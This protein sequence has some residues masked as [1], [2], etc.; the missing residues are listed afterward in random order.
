MRASQVFDQSEP[1]TFL[2]DH[3]VDD[4]HERLAF[5]QHTP[6]RMLLDGFGSAGVADAPWGRDASFASLEA[7]DLDAPA[8]HQSASFDFIASINSLDTV[9]DL[10]GA[11]IQMRELLTPGGLAIASFIGGSSLLKLR[12]IMLMADGDRPAARMH[13]LIDPRSCPQLLG[14][15]GWRN[16]V[17]DTCALRVRYSS[18]DRLV[19]DL[20]EQAM[21]NVLASHAPLTRAG[22]ARAQQAF[23]ELADEDGKLTETFEIITLTGWR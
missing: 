6:T 12:Q 18:L 14:R 7:G 5:L 15:A 11:L 9:N 1:A 13:P 22:M 4:A 10:P 17:V 23:A 2:L 19:Q 8:P 21:G 16:P 3:M 20:R